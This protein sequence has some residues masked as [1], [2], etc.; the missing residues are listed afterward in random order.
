MLKFKDILNKRLWHT[1]LWLCCCF[2]QVATSQAQTGNYVDIGAEA[3]NFGT[4]SLST[5]TNWSTARTATPGYFA[6]SGTAT[7]TDADDT[8]NINGYVKHYVTAA[9]QGFS[10]PVGTGTDLRTLTTSGTIP[11]GAAYGTAWILGNPGTTTDPT[12]N[13]THSLTALGTGV[14]SVST[15]GQWDWIEAA[16]SAAGITVTVSIPNLSSFGPASQLRLVGWDGTKWVNLSGSIGAS[17]NTENSTL[18]GTMI[19]GI[20][21]LGVGIGCSA[22]T[23]AP[24]LSAS[25]K[26][27]VCPA[28]T[29]DLTTITASN[30]PVGSVISWHTDTLATATN[31]VPTPSAVAAGNY[32]A[33]FYDST[34]A[35]FAGSPAGA[36]TSK[37]KVNITICDADGDGI[38]DANEPAGGVNDPCLPAQA[39]G[40]TGYNA[41]N[42]TWAAADCDGD[43]FTNGTE[44]AAG[45]DPYS[46]TSKPVDTDGDGTA[47]INEPSGGVNNPCLPAKPAGYTGYN[48]SNAIWAAA[49]CDG[50][51]FTNGAEAAAGSDPYSATSK[52]VDTD[53]DGITDNIDSDID[54]DGIANTAENA[55]CTPAATTCDSDGD[56]IPNNKDTDSDGDGISDVKEAGL[57][58]ANNDGKADGTPDAIGSVP[59][60]ITS[61]ASLPDANGNNKK[62]PYDAL[63]TDGD[64]IADNVDSDIDGDGIANTAEDAACSPAAATCDTDGDGIPNNKDTDS[65]GDGISDVKEAGLTDANNDGKADGTPDAT[66]SVPGTITSITTLPD[67]NGNS[68]KDPYDAADTDGDGIADNVDTDIDGDGIANTAEDAACSPAAATCDTDGDGIPNNK[69][70]DSDG[71]GISDVKEAGLTDANNDGKADGTP[72]ATGSVPGTITS[73]T[74]LPDANGNSKK[75]PYDALDTDGDGIADNVDT[76]LD[77]DGIANTVE[78]AVCSPATATCDSDGDGIPNSKDLDSDNDGVTDA[79]EAGLTDANGDGKADGIEGANGSIPGAITNIANVPDTDGDSK[80]NPYDALNGT[81]PDGIAAGIPASSINP[82]TGS[83]ICTTNCDPDGD[84]ILTP[85]DKL[86]TT[87]GTAADTDGDGVVDSVDADI[88]G[89]GIANTVEDAACSPAAATCDIDGDGVPNNKDMD[90]DNDGINDVIEA[91]L[92]D[93]DGD[94]KA[95]GTVGPNGVVS[96]AITNASSLGDKD[97]DAKK[98]PYDAMGGTVP[99]GTAA[100][101]PSNLIDP[102]TGKIICSTNCDPDKDGILTP[103]DGLPNGFG[104]A[105][106]TDGD[107]FPD[108][109]DQDDDGDGILDAVE[110]A[111][112]NP[113]SPTCDTDGDGLPNSMDMDS[114]NDGVNDVI[115]SGLSDADGDGKADGTIGANGAITSPISSPTSLTD[116]DSDGNKNPYDPMN[117]STPD[118]IAAGIPASMINP[119]T[120]LIIC[121]TNCDPDKDGILSP[122]DGLPNAWGD[123]SDTDNDGIADVNDLDDD[124]DGIADT[125]EQTACVPAGATCDTDG[126]GV[127]NSQDM[128]S[129]NDGVN[130]AIEA[131]FADANGDGKADGTVGANGAIPGAIT[132]VSGLNDTDGDGKKNPYD[133]ISGT[134][135]DGQAA[136]I[137][138]ALINPTTGTIICSTNCDPDKDGILTPVDGLPTAWGDAIDTDGDGVPDVN[139]IDDDGDGIVDTA[140]QAA[141]TPASATCDSDGDGLPNHLDLDSDNDGVNDAI[142]VGLTDADGDGKADGTINPITGAIANPITNYTTLTDKD[143]DGKKDLFDPL[144]GTIPDG[145]SAGVTPSLINPATGMINCTTNCDPDKDGI[146]SPIDGLPNNWGDAS[147]T[148]G[149]GVIDSVD[150]DDDGDGILDTAED[151]A[152]TPAVATCDTDG[153]GIPNNKDMD[154]DNDGINDVTEAGLTDADADGKADGTVGSN[155]AITNSVGTNGILPDKDSDMK[156]DPYD[157]LNGSTPDGAAAGIPS[158]LINPTTG[159][160]ICTTNCDPDKDGILSPIDGSPTI[161]GDATDSDGDGVLDSVDADDDGDGILD[162]VEQSGCTPALTTCD[163]DGDGVPNQLDM[164]SDND[165]IN[166]VT[167]AG[168]TDANGDGKAD[169]TIQANGAIA[170]P[171]SSITSLGDKDADGKKDLYDALAG[172]QPDGLS[173]GVNPALLNPTTGMIICTTNCDPDK[174]GI[175][176][177][178]DGLPNTF[179]DAIDTDSDGVPDSLDSDGD[180]D[181]IADTV[182][183]AACA[184]ASATCDTDGDGIPN[185]LD[186]D[187]D[188]DGIS[189]VKEAGVLDANG[190]GK[191]DGIVDATG[192]VPNTVTNI[193]SLAD[194][195]G[196]GRK[197][198]YDALSGTVPDGTTAGLPSSMFDPITGQVTCTT[199]C[200]PDKDGILTPADNLPNSFGLQAASGIQV[201]AKVFL[202][203]PLS[204]TT[205][206]TALNTQNLIPTTDPYGKGATTTS[207]TLTGNSITDWVLV[208]L[209][210][211]PAVTTA[212]VESIAALLK[213]DGTIINPDGSTPLKFT[214][215]AGSYYVSIRHRNHLGVMTSTALALNSTALVIDFT[216]TST[217][218]FGTNA[219]ATVGAVKAMWAGNA[220]GITLTNTDNVRYSNGDINAVTGYLTTQTGSPG[221]VKVSVYAKEDTNLDGTVRYSGGTR[222]VLPITNTILGNPSN[223]N[224]TS[225]FGFIVTQTF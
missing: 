217:A 18:S 37:A 25:T 105:I 8:H 72:D 190:D 56:G 212:P 61:L 134:V 157:A 164:D 211:A 107:G 136:G 43:G 17:A 202:Q 73:I 75:D 66:G 4:I 49:D 12:D 77:G 126:D 170:N 14:S 74:T 58:D 161:W 52:P 206:T 28:T 125:V 180:G 220:S 193:N 106:D 192:A 214:S 45:S 76:D 68:K 138:A 6:A 80:K 215:T 141:C 129:D 112:C 103:V 5:S 201:S 39:A 89:D 198:S 79:T 21:A 114:D 174:D 196:D 149:D 221:G 110:Q 102:I 104:D 121:S 135:P 98:D 218:T 15:V 223:P 36:A 11:N 133:A 123:A 55:A 182:E 146:L 213:N 32:F 94:G 27:N 113:A 42:A 19:T 10:F 88:D 177:P 64:G 124:G 95:D 203:G 181:G 23:S 47:D 131:G 165:G 137:P 50:D 225:G 35:C 53:G 70:T 16:G 90:S 13:V 97:A 208:E 210:S 44:A 150:A 189:D 122:I 31:K 85:V 184:P 197:D 147:D 40:Y 169:G 158:S 34:A 30:L 168:L 187:S 71:D 173:V 65:D 179:G 132:N 41:S 145:Y 78:D 166:D 60:T 93:A 159:T 2:F 26:S 63:D 155:G 172:T 199:N 116:A 142:E 152:C 33:V 100:G 83:V 130:D 51:G 191:A 22:G 216:S 127:P 7:Y 153:D 109:S 222:D 185:H 115:E 54:G 117:G 195:D 176:T 207:G 224:S 91:G 59:G 46:A 160:I 86:P 200:D 3:V 219:Q 175:L 148:D 96:T 194:K 81:S 111:A 143:G 128:D 139:D 204:G 209:R 20:K 62:D 144:S 171:V 188:N 24:T 48:A 9:N 84:G 82:A 69:D 186:L 178:L 57:T 163:T 38:A 67:A 205:M 156:K 167:E 151:S 99:D 119:T 183:Q 87:W 108:S 120:G 92:P 101:I 1:F 154:S 29:A 140:E 162:T 118:G